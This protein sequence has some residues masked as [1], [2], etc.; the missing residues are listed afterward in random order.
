MKKSNKLLGVFLVLSLVI[1]T[2]FWACFLYL[3]ALLKL[4][5]SHAIKNFSRRRLN[6]IAG[7]WTA[8]NI[9][10]VRRFLDTQWHITMP[11]HF[12]TDDWHLIIANHQT[13]LDIVVIQHAF[14]NKI[15]FPKFFLKDQLKWVPFLGLAWWAMEF[16]F[17]K[18]HSKQQ[19]INNHK[20]ITTNHK[21][22]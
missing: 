17:M 7:Y 9:I 5:P 13:W 19:I 1:S 16:P 10:F 15:P 2:V 11:D 8:T 4:I 18:R 14:H 12:T 6:Q 3:F 22:S 20:Q 21:K